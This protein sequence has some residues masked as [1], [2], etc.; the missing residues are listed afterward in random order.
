MNRKV[1]LPPDVVLRPYED[2][3]REAVVALRALAFSVLAAN[4]YSPEQLAASRAHAA[5]PAFA[6]E[7]R[8]I[9]LMLAVDRSG[10]V[11]GAAGWSAHEGEP[12][13]ARIRKVF[14][15]PERAQQGLGTT[16]V[17]D[18]ERRA[19]AAGYAQFAVRSSLNA[20]SFYRRLGYRS[21][22]S[23]SVPRP[24]DVRLPVTLMRKP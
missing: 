13:T 2:S 18:A 3:D 21:V 16:L 15:H 4:A 5:A 12:M 7:L 9:N 6:D 23:Q 22:E 17:L 14:V 1:S 10:G 24:G 11:L 20:V 8:R 19:A